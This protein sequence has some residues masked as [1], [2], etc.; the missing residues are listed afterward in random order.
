MTTVEATNAPAPATETAAN[1]NAAEPEGAITTVDPDADAGDAGK[2]KDKDKDKDKDKEKKP[3][4]PS[5]ALQVATKKRKKAEEEEARA[6]RDAW[7]RRTIAKL[8][9]QVRVHKI[10][11]T[12]YDTILET[13]AD[14][15]TMKR[16]M[17]RLAKI[18][19]EAEAEPM[20]PVD[21]GPLLDSSL[22]DGM[23]RPH[24]QNGGIADADSE[25]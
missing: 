11:E 17:L 21:F 14:P 24:H 10:R 12:H 23:I 19:R 9:K 22:A 20:P 18:T 8:T 6:T 3:L 5:G 13:T 2:K 7:A 1:T 25:E 4:T 16:A 15:E